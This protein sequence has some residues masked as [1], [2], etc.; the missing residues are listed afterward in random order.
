MS[1]FGTVNNFQGTLC[2]LLKATQNS[3]IVRS[4]IILFRVGP[5]KDPPGNVQLVREGMLP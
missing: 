4:C 3:A 2:M 1:T 5:S